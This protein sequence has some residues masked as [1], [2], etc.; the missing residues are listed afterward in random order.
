[1]KLLVKTTF[2][3]LAYSISP[4]VSSI[5]LSS[6]YEYSPEFVPTAETIVKVL[7]DLKITSNIS[8]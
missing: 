8:H 4:M 7:S 3:N 5:E 2:S 1:M 6:V